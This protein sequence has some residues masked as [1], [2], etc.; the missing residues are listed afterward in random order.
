MER[1]ERLFAFLIDGDVLHFCISLRARTRS[2]LLTALD[3]VDDRHGHFLIDKDD[4][5]A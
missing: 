1:H 3:V 5:Q 2:R 4:T